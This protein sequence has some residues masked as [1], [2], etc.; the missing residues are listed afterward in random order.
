MLFFHS[1]VQTGCEDMHSFV[2]GPPTLP[3]ILRYTQFLIH[4]L[5]KRT[6]TPF[7]N[8]ALKGVVPIVRIVV[9]KC[10]HEK[11]ILLKLRETCLDLCPFTHK[12]RMEHLMNRR[13]HL[14]A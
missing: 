6:H 4:E 11:S 2:V 13:H 14:D 5:V 12:G 9:D 8:E 1:R 10:L 3:G 7:F